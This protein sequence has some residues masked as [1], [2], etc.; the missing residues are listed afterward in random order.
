MYAKL[1]LLI[2][3]WPRFPAPYLGSIKN[4][5]FSI[6]EIEVPNKIF[7]RNIFRVS[8]IKLISYTWILHQLTFNLALSSQKHYYEYEELKVTWEVK[9][10]VNFSALILIWYFQY[11]N[12]FVSATPLK[13]LKRNKRNCVTVEY[14]MCRCGYSQE[15]RRHFLTWSYVPLELGNFT[16]IRYTVCQ[17][18]CYNSYL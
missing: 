13:P 8:I 11:F 3:I 4:R 18:N 10:W 9:E 12:F 17:R 7:I 16:K 14:M 1:F 5:I 2:F 6:I 15:I